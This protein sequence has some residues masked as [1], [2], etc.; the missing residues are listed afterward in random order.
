[1]ALIDDL[2]TL[3]LFQPNKIIIIVIVIIIIKYLSSNNTCFSNKKSE[4]CIIM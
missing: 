3:V 4:L 2:F 1:M